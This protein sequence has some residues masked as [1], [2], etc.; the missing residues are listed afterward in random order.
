[1]IPEAALSARESM[2]S[3]SRLRRASASSSSRTA[4]AR[5]R[6]TVSTSARRERAAVPSPTSRNAGDVSAGTAELA[7]DSRNRRRSAQC[8]SLQAASRFG[9]TPVRQA[10]SASS[11]AASDAGWPWF[12]LARERADRNAPTSLGA[13]ANGSNLLASSRRSCSLRIVERRTS[14]RSASIRTR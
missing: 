9:P 6:T 3:N 11:S 13:I 4:T 8:F 14:S 1:M 7:C 12:P 10:T 2:T 5:G